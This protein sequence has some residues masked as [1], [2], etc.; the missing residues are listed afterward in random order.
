MTWP[1]LRRVK[2]NPAF[3]RAL[4]DALARYHVTQTEL[5]R[6]LATPRSQSQVAHWCAGRHTPDLDVVV[7]I[8]RVLDMHPG[9]LTRLFGFLPVS[10]AE[11]EGECRGPA[12]C[13][14]DERMSSI[15]R[16][17]TPLLRDL[18]AQNAEFCADV[19][20]NRQDAAG[21]FRRLQS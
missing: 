10:V 5:G 17:I 12:V 20:A 9:T 16:S 4:T 21:A 18:A 8:E 6:S 3:A 2:P 7:D 14:V 11:A 13:A 1:T 15:L 19:E